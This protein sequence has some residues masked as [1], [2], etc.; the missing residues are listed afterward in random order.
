[1]EKKEQLISQAMKMS[2]AEKVEMI[3]R[4]LQSLDKPDEQIDKLWKKEAEDRIDA[5]DAGKISTVSLHEV[6]EKYK[7]D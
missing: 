2:P 1:M 7:G 6:V 4:L 3:E 5:Y